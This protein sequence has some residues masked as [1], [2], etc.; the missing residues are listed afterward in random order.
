MT[1]FYKKEYDVRLVQEYLNSQSA[2]EHAVLLL[3]AMDDFKTGNQKEGHT[4][5]DAVIQ[6]AADLLRAE[7]GPDQIQVRLGGDAFMLLI[8]N[9][10]K[11]MPPSPAPVSQIRSVSLSAILHF[12]VPAKTCKI[13]LLGQ[14]PISRNKDCF[15]ALPN[16]SQVEWLR[17]LANAVRCEA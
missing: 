5:A 6:E 13:H 4:F 10:D 8:K 2:G 11:A 1:G 16:V 17:L 7:T 12:F 3:L 9:S 15:V 14:P